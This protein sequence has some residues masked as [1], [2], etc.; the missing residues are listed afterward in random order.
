MNETEQPIQPPLKSPPKWRRFFQQNLSPLMNKGMPTGPKSTLSEFIEDN[1]KLISTLGVFLGLSV[2]ANNLPDKGAARL[3]S[4]LLFTLGVLVF[5][6]LVRKFSEFDWYGRIQTFREVLTLAMFVFVYLYVKAYYPFLLAWFLMAA[7][8]FAILVVFVLAQ[9]FV[10]WVFKMPLF[11]GLGQRARE[12]LI[13]LFGGMSLM[14]I[15]E[16]LFLHFRHKP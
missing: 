7:G 15:A 1:S 12:D 4:F 14:A 16:F 10:R 3:L 8:M 13:P 5:F 6:E 11:K 9:S 2:F